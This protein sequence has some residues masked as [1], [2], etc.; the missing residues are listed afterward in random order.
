M[1]EKHYFSLLDMGCTP[2]EARAVLPNSLK[3]ELV[4]TADI[5]EWRH[6]LKLRCSA[7]AHPQIREVATQLLDALYQEMPVLFGD[8]WEDYRNV[9]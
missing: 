9:F 2:Q 1:A 6:F 4:M 3:T 7:A 8:I 5:R